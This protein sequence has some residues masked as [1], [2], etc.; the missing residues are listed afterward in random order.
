MMLSA[1]MCGY[2]WLVLIGI[3]RSAGRSRPIYRFTA[4]ALIV[5]FV[6]NVI[7]G[8]LNGEMLREVRLVQAA[9]DSKAP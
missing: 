6:A 5:L 8:L 3:W 2:W 1:L 9:L 4:R 7:W